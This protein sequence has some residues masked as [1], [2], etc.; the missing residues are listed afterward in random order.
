MKRYQ[1]R[2]ALY[3]ALLLG[4]ATAFG[5]TRPHRRPHRRPYRPMLRRCALPYPI[6]S[7][8]PM[9]ITMAS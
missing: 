4:S 5:Q 8:P 1:Y 2:P 9:S 6:D 3:L 7:P